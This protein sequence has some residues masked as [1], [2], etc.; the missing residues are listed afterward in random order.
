MIDIAYHGS[1][2]GQ[3]KACHSGYHFLDVAVLFA[4]ES[5][6]AAGKSFDSV[7][8]SSLSV[9]PHD[10]SA[11][12]W[13]TDYRKVFGES[14]SNVEL[15]MQEFE[16]KVKNHGEIDTLV[17]LAFK[18][19]GKNLVIG[20][21]NLL[22]NSFS[23]RYWLDAV[24]EE[25]LYRENGRLRQEIH[26]LVQGPFQSIAIVSLRGCS[27]VPLKQRIQTDSSMEEPLEIHVFRN[28]GINS[29]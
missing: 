24:K 22:H 10:Y 28:T 26:Y 4:K 14:Y 3:G 23:G 5:L 29:T 15:D 6:S 1:N 18:K 8:V 7:E 12:M 20:N 21:L 25:N 16:N 9:F 27:K 2:H 17:S 19:D 11:I 13:N